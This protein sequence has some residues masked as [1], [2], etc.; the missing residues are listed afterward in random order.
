MA[1]LVPAIHVLS[2][3]IKQIPPIGILRVNKTYFP[4]T[5]PVLDCLLALNGGADIIVLLKIN[6]L[7]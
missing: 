7:F 2:Q 1:G 3:Y 4:C 5:W 6:E